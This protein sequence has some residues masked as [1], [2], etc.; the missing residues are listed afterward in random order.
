MKRAW[1]HRY[2]GLTLL[3]NSRAAFP[4]SPQKA[5]IETFLN[6]FPQGDY[7]INIDSP[8][9][10]SLCLVTRQSDFAEIY[11]SYVPNSK[12]LET[13]SL[14]LYLSSNRNVASFNEEAVN[15]ILDDLVSACQ[16]RRMRVEGKFIS[17][18]E[19]KSRRANMLKAVIKWPGGKKLENFSAKINH[20]RW[21]QVEREGNLV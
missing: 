3:G 17:H 13:K 8:E 7:W 1:N 21:D 16:P 15:R 14:K 20:F 18:G 2:P 12:F 11:I 10:T 4:D 19:N 9:F 6:P 5:K